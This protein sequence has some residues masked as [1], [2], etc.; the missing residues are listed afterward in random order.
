MLVWVDD[1]LVAGLDQ[2][3]IATVKDLLGVIMCR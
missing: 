1:I 3:E 2:E